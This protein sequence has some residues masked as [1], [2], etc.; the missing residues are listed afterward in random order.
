MITSTS[1]EDSDGNVVKLK[2]KKTGKLI[3]K[4]NKDEV[5][6]I[7]FYYYTSSQYNLIPTK[8]NKDIQMNIKSFNNE[9]IVGE[10]PHLAFESESADKPSDTYLQI[11][12][13]NRQFNSTIDEKRDLTDQFCKYFLK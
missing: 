9:A 13:D 11:L 10:N 1:V 5:I 3:Q 12:C 7:F 6:F 8:P 4:P 2:I